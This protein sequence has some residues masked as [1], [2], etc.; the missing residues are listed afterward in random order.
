MVERLSP[1]HFHLH[2]CSNK[3]VTSIVHAHCMI[4]YVDPH[5]CP[6]EPPQEDTNEPFLTE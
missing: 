1:V 6:T 4:L 2:T 5:D 3:Q